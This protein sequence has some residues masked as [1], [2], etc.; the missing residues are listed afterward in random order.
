M[1]WAYE[2]VRSEVSL[3]MNAAAY[4]AEYPDEDDRKHAIYEELDQR[5]SDIVSDAK[6][7]LAVIDSEWSAL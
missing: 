4:K 1:D 5:Y 6:T 2:Q 3:M 7:I